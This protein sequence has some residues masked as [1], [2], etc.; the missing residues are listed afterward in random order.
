MAKSD[1]W[2]PFYIG[3]Y[4]ADTMH[5]TTQ[6][7]GAYI[8]LL[9]AYYKN[10]GPLTDDDGQLSAIV[11]L[12]HSEWLAVRT[13]L[14]SFFQIGDGKWSHSRANHEIKIRQKRQLAAREGAAKT[15][16]G[17]KQPHCDTQSDPQCAVH[18][19]SQ[20]GENK[21]E[22]PLP[23]IPPMSRKDFDQLADMR[24]VLKECADYFW[25]EWDSRNWLDRFGNPLRKVEP[26]LLNFAKKWRQNGE[27]KRSRDALPVKSA[28]PEWSSG[29]TL[30]QIKRMDAEK[31]AM[32][33][34]HDTQR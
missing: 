4:L 30:E 7:H 10:Q 21:K 23:E 12:T 25:N 27:L 1:I 29:P 11:K 9:L 15:N 31:I 26:A 33:A 19:Q 28:H 13:A 16:S 24:G 5:L 6:Q 32:Y 22:P 14:A 34:P 8:L 3:D 2:F 20:L 17:K 18:S